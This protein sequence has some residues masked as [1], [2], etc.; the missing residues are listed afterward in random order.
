MALS[1]KKNMEQPQSEYKSVLK[2]YWFISFTFKDNSIKEHWYKTEEEMKNA[3]DK[4]KQADWGTDK[5]IGERAI[6][7]LS[8]IK[9]VE[10]QERLELEYVKAENDNG[11]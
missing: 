7:L 2:E 10:C 9:S 5:F 11:N 1:K 6:F 8:E 3:F 4:I